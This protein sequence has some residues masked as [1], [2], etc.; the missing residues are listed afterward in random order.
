M[1]KREEDAKKAED[2]KRLEEA[3]KEEEKRKQEAVSQ[4]A[5][6]DEKAKFDSHEKKNLG[7]ENTIKILFNSGYGKALYITGE[8][9]KLGNWQIAYKLNVISAGEWHYKSSNFAEGM[10][11]KI[12]IYNWVNAETINIASIPAKFLQWENKQGKEGNKIMKFLE[13][14]MNHSPGFIRRR[15]KTRLF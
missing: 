5:K 11:F 12:I 9:A 6:L 1:R 4:Q 10:S 3:K 8:D 2:A 15:S 14:V 13:N 7:I